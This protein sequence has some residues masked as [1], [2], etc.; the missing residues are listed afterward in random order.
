MVWKEKKKKTSILDWQQPSQK[1][2]DVIC[3]IPRQPPPF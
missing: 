1:L 3:P 2:K